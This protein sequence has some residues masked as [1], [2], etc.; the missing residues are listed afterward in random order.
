[1]KLI[2]PGPGMIIFAAALLL[3][4]FVL[5]CLALQWVPLL[6]AFDAIPR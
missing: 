5:A 2:R 4:L 3:R 6:P 1:M